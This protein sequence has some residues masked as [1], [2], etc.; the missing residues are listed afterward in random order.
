MRPVPPR[1]IPPQP[2]VLCNV[3][4]ETWEETAHM[5][6]HHATESVRIGEI[7][8]LNPHEAVFQGRHYKPARP[9]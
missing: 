1:P 6:K 7:L 9:S 8:W 5:T 4:M 2:C 3:E